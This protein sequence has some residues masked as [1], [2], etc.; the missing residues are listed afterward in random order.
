MQELSEL[1]ELKESNWTLVEEVKWQ[2]G[3]NP[4]LNDMIVKLKEENKL[5][6]ILNS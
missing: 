2:K 5:L 6:T 4:Q 1:K 3:L